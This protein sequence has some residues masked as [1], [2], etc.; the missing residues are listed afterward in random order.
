MGASPLL[1]LLAAALVATLVE[2]ADA[3]N[4]GFFHQYMSLRFTLGTAKHGNATTPPWQAL[5]FGKCL[6]EHAPITTHAL[7]V[8]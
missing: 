5:D 8:E 7:A 3:A 1:R 2:G 6:H 4:D